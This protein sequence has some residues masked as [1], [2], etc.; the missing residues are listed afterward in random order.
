MQIPVGVLLDRFGPQ[1]LLVAGAVFMTAAQLGF[2]YT[3]T[4]GGAL[5]A[6]VF[7]GMGDAMVFI[8][9]LRLIASWFPAFRS[10]L[11]TAFTAMLGQCGA[12]VAAIP[13]SRALAS[14]GWTATFVASASLGVLLGLLDRAG[15]ARRAAGRAA[16]PVGQGRPHRRARPQAGLARPGHPARAVVALH[17]PVRRERDGSAVGL[18]VLRARRAPLRRPR[19]A[20]C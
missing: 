13:L 15:G 12:L 19:P 2:A 7:V 5:V 20:R 1:R 3:G 16:V 10:P 11:L 8:S 6:R 14:Y 18:P 4:Y 17:H 9:V